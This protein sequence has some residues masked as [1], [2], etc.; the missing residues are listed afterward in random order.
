MF[1]RMVLAVAG[2]PA[3]RAAVKNSPLSRPVV[4]RFV[5]GEDDDSALTAV[6]A[7][8]GDGLRVTMDHLGEDI[9]D[10]LQA[11]ETVAAYR[12][13]ISRLADAGL[14]TG[15]EISIKLSALG[16]SLGAD[17]PARATEL[18]HELTGHAYANGV[19]VTLDMEDHTTVDHTL[20]TLR[21]LRTDHPR[22]GCVLQAM[23]KRTEG[24]VRDLGRP[25]SRVRLVKGAY[26]E[27]ASVAHTAKPE[28]DRA[29]VRCLR[30]LAGSG[31]YP[32]VAT[33]D[34]RIIR[35]AETVLIPAGAEAEFQMLFGIRTAEQ[36]R[37]AAAGH[38]VR[39]YVPYGT[40]WYGYFSRRLAERPA[41]VGFFLR[42][43]TSR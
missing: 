23:L 19:D 4:S 20:G 8:H 35:I 11:T 40:D 33:H 39:V 29:Y 32:M 12:K 2:N 17:G 34:P 31:A 13:L 7:L 43:L 22:V 27:P 26:A 9:T 28:V 37:L 30:L 3:M 1:G 42:S 36:L 16:Q 5:A 15:N 24:D 38:T 10:P 25:G 14:A 41:N 18:A 6:L 21:S